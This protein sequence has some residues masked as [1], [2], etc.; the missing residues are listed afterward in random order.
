MDVHTDH[1][2][3]SPLGI[4]ILSSVLAFGGGFAT[5]DYF[6]NRN[7]S[8]EAEVKKQQQTDAE[9]KNLEDLT[10]TLE[11]LE[12]TEENHDLKR[13]LEES[14]SFRERMSRHEFDAGLKVD[15][16]HPTILGDEVKILYLQLA[17]LLQLD[18]LHK[19]K[20]DYGAIMYGA[21][22]IVQHIVRAVA[23]QARSEV[24]RAAQESK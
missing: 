16:F 20:Q 23:S 24:D 1:R 2:L 12:L 19:N 5:N 3:T 7:I 11:S 14:R 8:H 18:D 17:V 9:K 4:A 6:F 10:Q 22:S 13:F 21:N 15:I